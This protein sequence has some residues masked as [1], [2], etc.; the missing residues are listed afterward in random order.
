M[1]ERHINNIGVPTEGPTSPEKCL[2]LLFALLVVIFGSVDGKKFLCQDTLINKD[3]F[4][5][6]LML[7]IGWVYHT[8][9]ILGALSERF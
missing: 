3:L 4:D 5:F 1:G 8:S 9:H 6:E 7:R 2:S